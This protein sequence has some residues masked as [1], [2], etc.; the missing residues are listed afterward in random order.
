MKKSLKIYPRVSEPVSRY[1]SERI[2]KSMGSSY[3]ASLDD[4]STCFKDFYKEAH[5]ILF[6][7]IVKQVWLE[8]KF[9]FA[10]VRR[11]RRSGNGYGCDWAFSFFMN[12]IVGISQKPLTTGEVFVKIPTYFKDFFPNFSDHDPFTEPEYF[13]YPYKHVT[14][15][16]LFVV[17]QHHDRIAMLDYAEKK[18]MNIREFTDWAINQAMGYNDEVGEEVYRVM[19]HAYFFPFLKKNK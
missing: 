12:G 13:K 10:N 15:D 11:S 19:R 7:M 2:L 18:K 16:F 1:P 8:Q 5:P 14:L 17:Y 6:S 3:G 4:L 9:V